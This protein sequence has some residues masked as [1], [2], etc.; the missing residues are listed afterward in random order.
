MTRIAV[1]ADTIL[2]P[3]S[4]GSSFYPA[5]EIQIKEFKSPYVPTLAFP[6]VVYRAL[7]EQVD[8]LLVYDAITRA[9]NGACTE[10]RSNVCGQE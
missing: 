9:I 8:P 10:R 7:S 4:L 2:R 6:A 3:G 5:L 1:F